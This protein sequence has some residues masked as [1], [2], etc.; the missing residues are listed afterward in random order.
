VA[1]YVGTYVNAALGEVKV[2]YEQGRLLLDAGEFAS[3]ARRTG[4]EIASVS[5][6]I[7]TE[8]VMSGLLV[9]FTTTDG[10]PTLELVDRTGA[11]NYVFAQSG[12]AA[13]PV[14]SPVP[15]P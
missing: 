2:T 1:P 13:T 4:G 8:G 3:E 11:G 10:N 9:T 15:L 5:D 6:Y 7:L 14:A 12:E